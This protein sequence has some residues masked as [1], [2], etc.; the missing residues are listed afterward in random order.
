LDQNALVGRIAE[1]EAALAATKG[2]ES[3]GEAR[4]ANGQWDTN[5]S[6][7]SEAAH[8]MAA[9]ALAMIAQHQP[10][11]NTS[12]S[13]LFPMSNF[14]FYKAKRFLPLGDNSNFTGILLLEGQMSSRRIREVLS[15]L[16]DEA[17]IHQLME[18]FETM[19]N[20]GLDMGLSIYLLKAQLKT[21]EEVIHKRKEE[22]PLI[23]DLS[24]VALLFT[25]LAV[26]L[27]LK[28][29]SKVL[30][31]MGLTEREATYS[32]MTESQRQG[33]VHESECIGNFGAER[34]MSVMSLILV[35]QSRI[36]GTMQVKRF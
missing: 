26:T 12:S 13:P 36:Y 17:T 6:G 32:Y 23:L 27:E 29:V 24:F 16:P 34:E 35:T 18:D 21:M 9:D 11:A 28:D 10:S 7:L 3:N 2:E 25:L 31:D 33:A 30:L 15:L 5:R 8:G 4:D 19:Q 20:F 1:L 14:T 22:E